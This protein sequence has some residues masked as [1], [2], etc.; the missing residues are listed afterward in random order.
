MNATYA[1]IGSATLAMLAGVMVMGDRPR[2]PGR[3]EPRRARV[4]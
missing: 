1:I 2:A 4:R 3:G